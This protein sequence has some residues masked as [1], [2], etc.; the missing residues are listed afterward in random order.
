MTSAQPYTPVRR[1]G[2]WLIVSGQ[3]GVADGSLVAGGAE[4]EVVAALDNLEERLAEHGATLADVVK[5]TVFL[6]NLARDLPVVNRCYLERFPTPRPARSAIGVTDL[7][8]GATVEIEAM[9][10]D[11][12]QPP[13]Q[14]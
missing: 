10:A 7:P 2:G 4:V 3:L 8:L 5:T 6:T 13:R 9:A 1:S 14:G 12:G 11:L